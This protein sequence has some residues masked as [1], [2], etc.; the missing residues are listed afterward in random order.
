MGAYVRLVHGRDIGM[1]GEEAQHPR[2]AGSRRAED[3][4]EFD[5]SVAKLVIGARRNSRRPGCGRGRSGPPSVSTSRASSCS[6]SAARSTSC[7]SSV[8]ARARRVAP[9]WSDAAAGPRPQP[10]C[11]GTPARARVAQRACDSPAPRA[12]QGPKPALGFVLLAAGT[13]ELAA[14][15]D[16]RRP[17][18]RTVLV[19]RREGVDQLPLL[20][21]PLVAGVSVRVSSRSGTE[22]SNPSASAPCRARR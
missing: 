1:P 10:V 11:E 12:L 21:H 16:D 17:E 20:A 18:L 13:L 8:P 3:P 22:V 9:R 4:D 15:I 14:K 7:A 5:S 19:R 6:C 2:A